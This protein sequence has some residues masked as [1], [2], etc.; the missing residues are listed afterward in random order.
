MK[1]YRVLNEQEKKSLDEKNN[2]LFEHKTCK[3]PEWLLNAHPENYRTGKYFF[4]KL[5]DACNYAVLSDNTRG[6][7][8]IIEI[9][10]DE[11]LAREHLGFGIYTY[12]DYD[13]DGYWDN[14]YDHCIP[15]VLLPYSEVQKR[16]TNKEYRLIEFKERGEIWPAYERNRE[17]YFVELGKFLR[18]V[19]CQRQEIKYCEEDKRKW[20]SF[21][22]DSKSLT[23]KKN[24]EEYE[25]KKEIAIKKLSKLANEFPKIFKNFAEEHNQY[26]YPIPNHINNENITE[27]ELQK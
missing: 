16:L 1:V 18:D 8:P 20:M 14:F 11:N 23:S 9:D 19:Y 25:G 17:K 13:D 6:T 24:I 22:Q 21:Y 10:I 26:S 15:E 4:F 3:C 2:I 27:K 5:E 7:D 12:G